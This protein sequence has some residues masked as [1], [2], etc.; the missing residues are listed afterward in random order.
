MWWARL[1]CA[2]GLHPWEPRKMFLVDRRARY[3]ICRIC[4][5][6]KPAP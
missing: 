4:G 6:M 2:F 5:L 3:A 1:R